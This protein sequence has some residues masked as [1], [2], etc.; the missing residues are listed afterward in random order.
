MGDAGIQ[1][2]FTV[3]LGVVIWTRQVQLTHPG[4]FS[5]ST[6]LLNGG[7]IPWELWGSP[8]LTVTQLAK[9]VCRVEK[10]EGKWK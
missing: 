8:H 10:A 7:H 9:Q 5:G 6:V 4:S 2:C 1:E 3:S